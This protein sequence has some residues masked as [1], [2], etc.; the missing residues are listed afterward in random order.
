MK[1][2]ISLLILTLTFV[3]CATYRPV[4]N[5]NAQYRKVGEAQAE[6]DIDMCMQRAD[7]F[8]E[9]HKEER[10]Q[11][12]AGREAVGGA[13][14]GGVLGL[15]SGR[16]AEAVVGGVAG[17]AAIGATGGYLG[18]KSKDNLKPDEMKQSYVMKCLQDKN[19]EILGWK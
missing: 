3:S 7:S 16:G 14:V 10:A 19:Y 5:D 18:E 12:Q 11:K 2:R 13:I 8:L 1:K 15:V 17:G 9:K 4:L 6:A